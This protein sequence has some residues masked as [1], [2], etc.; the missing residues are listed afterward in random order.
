MITGQDLVA[1]LK[2]YPVRADVEA[3]IRECLTH[4]GLKPEVIDSLLFNGAIS[5]IHVL[6]G[7]YF[8]SDFARL[9]MDNAQTNT[10]YALGDGALFKYQALIRTPRVAQLITSSLRKG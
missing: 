7:C 1:H 3:Q 5:Q 2:T 6:I 4:C 8:N 10:L 9:V